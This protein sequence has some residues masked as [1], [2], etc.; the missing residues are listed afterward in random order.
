MTSSLF[1]RPGGGRPGR[2]VLAVSPRGC[3]AG[4]V[5]RRVVRSA[6]T[7]RS[8][9]GSLPPSPSSS[10]GSAEE[11]QRIMTLSI[12][13]DV[14]HSRMQRT[15]ACGCTGGLRH[16]WSCAAPGSSTSRPRCRSPGTRVPLPAVRS[17]DP[18]LHPPREAE[19]QPRRQRPATASPLGPMDTQEA[20]RPRRALPAVSSSPPKS[21]ASG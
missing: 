10:Y 2:G 16:R 9:P 18:R 20:Q 13:E 15:V 7:C 14:Y 11:A 21:N 3:P 19:A 1:K 5:N 6:A 12:V 17:P 4:G 8:Q